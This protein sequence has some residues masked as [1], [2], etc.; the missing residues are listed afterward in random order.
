MVFFV[1]FSGGDDVDVEI[2][3]FFYVFY[4]DFWEDGEVSDIEVVVILVVEFW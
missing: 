2:Y 4:G 1:V 3:V